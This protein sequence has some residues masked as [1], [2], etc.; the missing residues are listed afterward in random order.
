[1][2]REALRRPLRRYGTER[3]YRGGVSY[4]IQELR[5]VR[6]RIVSCRIQPYPPPERAKESSTGFQPN[7]RATNKL[8]VSG[9]HGR[10]ARGHVEHSRNLSPSREADL[11]L[12]EDEDWT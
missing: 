7:R 6:I 2:V 4:R 8:R 12:K 3:P 1:M 9:E 10:A 5:L 11:N